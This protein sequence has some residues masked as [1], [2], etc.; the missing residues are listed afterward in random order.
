MI[1]NS[2]LVIPS[3]LFQAQGGC[4]L[5]FHFLLRQLT[6]PLSPTLLQLR[7]VYSLLNTTHPFD[8]ERYRCSHFTFCQDVHTCCPCLSAPA[9]SF[10]SSDGE[11]D[12]EIGNSQQRIIL[13]AFTSSLLQK[14]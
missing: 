10:V 4:T 13:P 8:K 5:L 3:L 14:D 12:S 9:R 2:N 6:K 11:I 1:R 7:Q